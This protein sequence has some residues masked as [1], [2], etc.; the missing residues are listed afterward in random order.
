M[1]SESRQVGDFVETPAMKIVAEWRAEQERAGTVSGRIGAYDVLSLI[2]RGGMGEVYLAHDTRLGRNVAVKVLQ[3]SLTSNEDAVR[4][5]E[6]EARA[7]SSLNHPNI[8]TI[9][10]I[11]DLPGRRFLAMEFVDGRSLA[12]L[13]GAPM[14]IERLARVGVQLARALG[15]A[16]AAGIVHRDIKPENVILRTD[17]YVKVLDFGLARLAPVLPAIGVQSTPTSPSVI[18]GTPRYMSPEQARGEVATSA[19]D[20]FSFGVLLY[21][22][23]TGR[24]PFD[25]QTV[26]G[27]LHAIATAAVPDP[28]EWIPDMPPVLERLL[29]RMLEKHEAARPTAEEVERDLSRLGAAFM[30]PADAVLLAATRSPERRRTTLPSQRTSL[31]GRRSELVAVKGMLLDPSV[32]LLTLTGPGGT[33]KTR[34]GI[35]IADDLQHLFE[36][37]VWFVNLAPLSD[38]ALVASAIAWS[39]GVR[40]SGDAPLL[41]TLADHVRGLG[42]TLLLM[43]NFEQVTDAAAVVKEL[44]D[45]CPELK[46]LA[47]SRIVLRIYGEQEFPVPPLALPQ[48]DA[49]ASPGALM[50]C[51]SI[52]LFVQRAAASRPDFVLTRT[53]AHAVVEI[54]RRLDG[55]PLAIELAAARVKILPPSELLARMERPLELLTGGARDL[56]ERQQTLREAIRWSYDLLTPAEQT[57]FRRLS[58][59]RGGCTLEA[60]E[61]VANAHEDL[62][63]DVLNGIGSLV[64]NSLLVQRTSDD[65]G[66]RFVLLETFREYGREQL[67]LAGEAQ[68]I[69]RAHAAYMLVLAEEETLDM[70]PSAREAWLSEC[71]NEHDNFR[72]ALHSLIDAGDADWALRLGAA[73]FRF[74]EQRDHLSEGREALGR[75]LAMPGAIAPTRLRARALH[76]ASVLADIQGDLAAAETLSR[77]ASG[78]Y[79]ASGD[80]QGLA[81]AMTVTA[82][83]AQRQGRHEDATALFSETVAL[84]E[85]L[86]DPT[87]VDL[88]TSNMAHAAKTGGDAGLARRLLEQVAASSQAR[89][90]V[91]GF[92]FAL[93]GLGDVA[94]STGDHE[95]A[96]RYHLES[97]AR[98]REIEDRWGI[99]RVLSDLGAL[100]LDTA[101][102]R[103]ADRTLRDAIDA[104]RALG[105]QRGVARHLELLAWCAG[106]Q[107][108]HA[109]AVTLAG[110]ATAIRDR[111]AAPARPAELQM[112]E[113][114]LAQARARLAEETYASAWQDGIDAGVED[115]R[116]LETR[117]APLT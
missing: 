74:W 34:L 101:D 72:A 20:V 2:G 39:L 53:N 52:A 102:Y 16:H 48:E 110:A 27:T 78:I 36:G 46:V 38:S 50:Q 100:Q 69:E 41:K 89:G 60:A 84:W 35:R 96:R 11:G 61:A 65:A 79:R 68:A 112:V 30:E 8:V 63:I 94:A 5:F 58:I 80:V 3:S 12:S 76:C 6:Q 7:A 15:V 103:E 105:H 114:T 82:Y 51:P 14:E 9:Y 47:T 106:S 113:R 55:L 64:D 57:L 54:C 99:A 25:S 10:E 73:L 75:V 17:G 19:S 43:D 23:A 32:R 98:Y 42:S 67:V 109:A 62:G 85:Q 88:A 104:F 115:L 31:V 117:G 111:I 77:E 4:R 97:L 49:F 107:S 44:L 56:P 24:H 70:T 116:A 29:F 1:A 86:G 93:N 45:A 66:G 90:D 95:S 13:V 40:E 59:F 81:T 83:Q 71:D 87:A 33:G 92:A 37:G 28:I 21:E 18:L 26:L 108:R 91:R 22:L